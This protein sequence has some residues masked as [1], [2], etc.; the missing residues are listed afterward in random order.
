MKHKNELFYRFTLY[1][2][3]IQK[4][5]SDLFGIFVEQGGDKLNTINLPED[6]PKKFQPSKFLIVLMR[7]F[8][9]G[10]KNDELSCE[11]V[12]SIYDS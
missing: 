10:D 5:A 7:E 6:H 8:S 9:D 11:I 12:S 1:E 2:D 3:I 4:Q